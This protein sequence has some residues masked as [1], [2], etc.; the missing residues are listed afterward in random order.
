MNKST[1][2]KKILNLEFQTFSK[3]TTELNINAELGSFDY[4]AYGMFL[5]TLRALFLQ[6]NRFRCKTFLIK[7]LLLKYMPGNKKPTY[8]KKDATHQQRVQI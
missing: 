7:M 1:Y 3:A 6:L 2:L 4:F 5:A 8:G